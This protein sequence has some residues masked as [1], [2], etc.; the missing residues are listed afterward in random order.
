MSFM[1]K[2]DSY[3][4]RF[5]EV[6]ME[7]GSPDQYQVIQAIEKITPLKEGEI[8]HG[9]PKKEYEILMKVVSNR[10]NTITSHTMT[11][12]EVSEYIDILK[13][14]LAQTSN[15]HNKKERGFVK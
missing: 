1:I 15:N 7:L 14:M 4:D 6:R 2:Y 13:R 3:P 9:V 12:E 10:N 8:E 5:S 11:R